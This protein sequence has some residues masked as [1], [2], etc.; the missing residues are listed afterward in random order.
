MPP[1]LTLKVALWP[2]V[3]VWSVG[4]A[5]IVGASGVALTV[6]CAGALCALPAGLVTTTANIAPSSSGSA[7]CV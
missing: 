1:A 7:I 5:L 3:I 6:S 2:V 4:G